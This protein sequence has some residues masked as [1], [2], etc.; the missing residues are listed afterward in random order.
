LLSR[1]ANRRCGMVE[2]IQKNTLNVTASP[3]RGRQT[4]ENDFGSMVKRG[5]QRAVGAVAGGARF[6]ASFLPGGGFISAVADAVDGAVG[7]DIGGTGGKWE[8]LR[9]QERL[10]EEGISNSLRL[11]A[12][13]R[14]M[15]KETQNYTAI[16]NVMKARHEMA[17]AAINNI[18]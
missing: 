5:A 18:R 17:K 14:E 9:A 13:Q 3:A 11:L 15:N 6:A 8:L 2:A 4:A 16:S 12:L 10:Q 1:R 7:N